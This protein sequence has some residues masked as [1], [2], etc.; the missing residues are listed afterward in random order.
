MIELQLIDKWLLEEVDG[1]GKLAIDYIC[2]HKKNVM[3]ANIDDFRRLGIEG[4]LYEIIDEL[5][6]R[7]RDIKYP[8]SAHNIHQQIAFMVHE[9]PSKYIRIFSPKFK[10]RVKSEEEKIKHNDYIA[11]LHQTI[12]IK[13][14]EQKKVNDLKT[15]EISKKSE[16]R[17]V[18]GVALTE[19]E[20]RD[21]L[22]KIVDDR[23]LLTQG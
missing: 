23:K 14:E 13:R 22:K 18:I 1:T 16:K 6:L 12:S 19:K 3:Y 10:G 11:F 7:F 9:K 8:I 20:K 2:S 15:K 4:N 21:R 17:F 5:N